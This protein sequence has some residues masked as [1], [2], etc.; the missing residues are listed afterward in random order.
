MQSLGELIGKT[1]PLASVRLRQATVTAAP[2]VGTATIRLGGGTDAA[3]NIS[4]VRMLANAQVA[5]GD[6]VWVLQTGGS[7]LVL[8][9]IATSSTTGGAD[10]TYTGTVYA[11]R[12]VVSPDDFDDQKLTLWS[13]LPH[14]IGIRANTL[15]F[16]VPVNVGH[17]FYVDNVERALIDA[18]GVTTAYHFTLPYQSWLYLRGYGDASHSL[19]VPPLASYAASVWAQDGPVLS[20]WAHVVLATASGGLTWRL[21][22]GNDYACVRGK[23]SV[24]SSATND[25]QSD[26]E[27]IT[28][29][30][31]GS[32]ISMRQRS[33]T[34]SDATNRFAIYTTADQL[35][36][37]T[38]SVA[39]AIWV[40]TTGQ[41]EFY[42]FDQIGNW[43]ASGVRLHAQGAATGCRISFWSQGQGSAPILKSWG[44]TFEFRNNADSGFILIR[45]SVFEVNST[46]E[47][48]LAIRLADERLSRLER[49][50]RHRR[51]RSVHFHRP[52]PLGCASCQGTGLAVNHGDLN[53]ATGA[54]VGAL[55]GGLAAPCPDCGGN[56][57]SKVW[58][59]DLK[60]E[61]HGW[62]GFVA[63]EVVA[64][65]PEVVAWAQDGLDNPPQPSGLDMMG[66]IAVLWELVRDLDD[67]IDLALAPRVDAL[68]ARIA[69][70]E[71]NLAT[72]AANNVRHIVPTVPVP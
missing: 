17:R 71:T 20:G 57:Q 49:R 1:D 23:L 7:L 72:H 41:I 35:R 54:A 32:G 11:D 29:Y 46:R 15:G 27:S 45:A 56:P 47:S 24:G 6:T 70:L 10:A 38:P 59:S 5:N 61:E 65:F 30:G 8:G 55:F 34:W 33:R 68:Q 52:N 53:T 19:R 21:V 67:R 64:E 43:S 51:L 16:F 69:T 25:A 4:G 40:D 28:T 50:R 60:S 13:T 2:S 63:E 39:D 9:K 62:F 3:D 12:F 48:K 37:Y 36:I 26:F 42:R 31:G 14:S 18:N 44:E 58:A 22:V 66:L